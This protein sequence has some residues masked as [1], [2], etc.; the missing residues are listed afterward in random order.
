MAKMKDPIKAPQD[1]N[2]DWQDLLLSAGQ[3]AAGGGGMLPMIMKM[4]ME[5]R[6]GRAGSAPD[7]MGLDNQVE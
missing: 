5:M 4:M 1:P 3:G 7:S 2:W 6:K